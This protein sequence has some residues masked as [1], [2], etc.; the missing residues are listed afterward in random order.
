MAVRDKIS[1]ALDR[2]PLSRAQTPPAAGA[3]PQE[4]PQAIYSSSG[5]GQHPVRI[6]QCGHL[7]SV[8]DTSSKLTFVTDHVLHSAE[9]EQSRE[10]GRVREKVF[11]S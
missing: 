11:K 10:R 2:V 1:K 9:R 6:V 8:H 5:T 7:G 4:V 3:E